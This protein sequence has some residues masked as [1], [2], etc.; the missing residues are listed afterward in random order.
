MLHF[1]NITCSSTE[2]GRICSFV[3][4]AVLP[5]V[6]QQLRTA[7]LAMVAFTLPVITAQK[8]LEIVL[9]CVLLW[10]WPATAARLQHGF[11]TGYIVCNLTKAAVLAWIVACPEWWDFV[12]AIITEAAISHSKLRTFSALYA[13]MD[14]AAFVTNRGMARSTRVHHVLVVAVGTLMYAFPNMCQAPA[15]RVII[16]YTLWS[17]AAFGVNAMLAFHKLTGGAGTGLPWRMA[18]ALSMVVYVTSLILNMHRQVLHLLPAVVRREGVWVT[19]AMTLTVGAWFFDDCKLC[20][21]LWHHASKPRNAPLSST[22][23]CKHP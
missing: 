2:S 10:K 6:L 13:S 3:M 12:R 23:V 15:G 14:V 5:L 1:K 8:L 21:F 16:W 18:Y 7:L 17:C 22:P 4:L 19:V 11:S 20:S 9:T